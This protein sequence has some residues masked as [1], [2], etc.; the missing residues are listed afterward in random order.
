LY[1]RFCP[2][3]KRWADYLRLHGGFESIGE[4][5]DINGDALISDPYL[6]R[7]G[8]NVTLSSCSLICHDGSIKQIFNATGL[9]VDAVGKIDIKDNCFIGFGATILRN[10]TIGPNSIVAAG[11]VVTKDVPPN[12]VVAGIPAVVIGTIEAVA[13]KLQDESRQLPWYDIIEKRNGS[14]DEN[15]EPELRTIR[16]KFFWDS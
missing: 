16:R 15:V 4:N 9:K 11:A 1:A 12:S 2:S 13:K 8:K 7:L 3:T 10:V 6:V 5:C 14:F